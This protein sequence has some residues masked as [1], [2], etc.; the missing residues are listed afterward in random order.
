MNEENLLFQTCVYTSFYIPSRTFAAISCRSNFLFWGATV[1]LGIFPRGLLLLLDPAPPPP[2]PVDL[3]VA[4][5]EFADRFFFSSSLLLLLLPACWAGVGW[6]GEAG[7]RNRI[8]NGF[9]M[10]FFSLWAC[11]VPGAAWLRQGISLSWCSCYVNYGYW[12]SLVTDIPFLDATVQNR[13]A[14]LVI[15][16][17]ELN[18]KRCPLPNPALHYAQIIR[19]IPFVLRCRCL[20]LRL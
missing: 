7:D 11:C 17:G 9:D 8:F 16:P 15:Q 6:S 18:T 19:S 14:L 20:G 3:L 13:R 4:A 1:P 12:L 2:L 5:P 10:M